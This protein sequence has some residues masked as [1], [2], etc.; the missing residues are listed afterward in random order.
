MAEFLIAIISILLL[1][2]GWLLI[3]HWTR[4][5]AERHPEF[6]PAKEEGS[7]CGKSCLCSNG[8]CKSKQ[9]TSENIQ[10]QSTFNQEDH[11]HDLPQ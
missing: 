4:Q 8:R 3:Q 9:Q 7:G 1:L 11:R 6:G 2:S 5:Y 10:N